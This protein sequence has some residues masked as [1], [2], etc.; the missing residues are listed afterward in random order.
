MSKGI[1]RDNFKNLNNFIKNGLNK[2]I[3]IEEHNEDQIF[4]ML[5]RKGVSP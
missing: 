1:K 2:F 4:K 5:S 3:N